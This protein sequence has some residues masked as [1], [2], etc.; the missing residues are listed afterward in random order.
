MG[1]PI[2]APSV[3]SADFSDM[4]SGLSLI[5]DSG[6]DWVHLDVMDGRF[7]P[8]ITFGDKMAADLRPHSSLPFD[9]HLMTVE[10]ERLVQAFIEA[11]ANMVTFHVEACVHAH[12]LVQ[13][14]R[15]AGVRPGVSIVPSTPVSALEELLPAVDIVLVMTVNPGFGGQSMIPSCLGKVRRL[16]EMRERLGLNFLV[17]VDGGVNRTTFADVASAGA[18]VLVMGSAFFSSRDP[19]SEIAAAREAFSQKSGRMGAV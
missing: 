3:L 12:R 14:L 13:T 6:A 2:I 19:G 17:S 7:V 5:A 8:N 4:R 10:P 16:V 15:A 11:G 9:V 18:D 1:T